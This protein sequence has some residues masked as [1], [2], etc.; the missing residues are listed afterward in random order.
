VVAFVLAPRGEGGEVR[1]GIGLG[2]AL[3]PADLAAG[4][5]GQEALLLRLGA[6]FE[7]RRA[8]HRDAEAHQRVARAD[9]RHFP[10][11]GLGLGRRQAAAAIFLRPVGHRPA[12]PGHQLQPFLLG[13]ILEHRVPPA[14]AHVAFVAH[15][16][17]HL[18]RA[19][20]LEPGASF[21]AEGVEIG[22]QD[23][24]FT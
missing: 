16:L 20:G 21:G 4:D 15:R 6:V 9:R 17:A 5:L 1:A 23:S 7:Q 11:E 24:P 19:I 13:V 12:A 18:G 8:E 22:H 2:I 14:P 10:L 3:A